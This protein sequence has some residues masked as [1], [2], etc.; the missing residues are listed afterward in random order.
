MLHGCHKG[1]TDPY[2]KGAALT[3]PPGD[4][5]L[6]EKYLFP[7]CAPAPPN[8]LSLGVYQMDARGFSAHM[9]VAL[10]PV[11]KNLQPVEAN[12]HITVRGFHLLLSVNAYIDFIQTLFGQGDRI[13][14]AED[15]IGALIVLVL[16]GRGH[17]HQPQL[18]PKAFGGNHQI[19]NF[20]GNYPF[21]TA[22]MRYP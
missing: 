18:V 11:D 21:F 15:G 6:E 9:V 12:F 7:A 22:Q 17:I 14:V 5:F 4:I 19:G 13:A 1:N 3:L 8:A 16:I 10:G 2:G 20:H